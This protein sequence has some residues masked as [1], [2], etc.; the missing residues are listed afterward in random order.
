VSTPLGQCRA[1][2]VAANVASGRVRGGEPEGAS[3]DYEGD[4]LGAG[5]YKRFVV[6]SNLG[7][8]PIGQAPVRE[9]R[10]G[11]RAYGV[12]QA[13]AELLAEEIEAALH[14]P[15]GRAMGA[16]W[17]YQSVIEES[18]E[19]RKDPDTSQPYESGIITLIA[20]M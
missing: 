20:T 7:R 19:G 14:L 18:G 4:A 12:N 6:L 16:G 9:V 17:M 5:S 8:S 1:D 13:D 3:A 15:G 10:V 2:L 11:F